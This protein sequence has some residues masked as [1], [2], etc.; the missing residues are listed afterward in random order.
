MHLQ[1]CYS[2]TFTTLSS[3]YLIDWWCGV[4]FRLFACWFD[5]RFCYSYLTWETGG[6]KLPLTIIY[7][8][9][10][11]RLRN[12]K[13]NS[14]FQQVAG[15]VTMNMSVSVYS[16]SSSTSKVWPVQLIFIKEILT[17]FSFSYYSFIM[18]QMI[19]KPKIMKSYYEI[20]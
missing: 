1:N 2:M 9:Q 20:I 15:L 13:Q 7:E 19:M 14:H 8:L 18:A 16:K 12:Q 3:Y 11:N 5:F 17:Y 6:L 10:A 4:D